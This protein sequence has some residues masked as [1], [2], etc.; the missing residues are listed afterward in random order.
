MSAFRALLEGLLS[1]RIRPGEAIRGLGEYAKV[2][3]E[4]NPA[5]VEYREPCPDEIDLT[6]EAVRGALEAFLA[7][8]MTAKD[9]RDWALFVTLS[10]A[11]N[12]PQ[13]NSDDEDWFDP[14]WDVVHDLACPEVHGAITSEGVRDHLDTLRRYEGAV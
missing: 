13:H 3:F 14:M 7:E 9:L 2:D 12:T 5:F 8:Q 11:Y 4:A 10:G 1:R 6:P